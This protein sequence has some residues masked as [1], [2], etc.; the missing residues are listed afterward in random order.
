MVLYIN[1]VTPKSRFRDPSIHVKEGLPSLQ[2]I[3]YDKIE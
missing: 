1:Y 3:I 2:S